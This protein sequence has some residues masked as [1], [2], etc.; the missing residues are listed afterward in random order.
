MAWGL[1][2][3]TDRIRLCRADLRRGRIHLRRA[4]ESPL[5]LGLVRASVKDANVTDAAAL[6]KVLRDL[7]RHAGCRGWVRVALPDPVFILRTVATEELPADRDEA[8][9]FLCWQVRDLLPFSAEHARLDFVKAGS[10][11]DGRSRFTCL[12]AND[13]IV[14]EY[15][16][17]L[18]AADLLPGALD[19][20]SVTLAQ[21]ASALL[22]FPSVGLL[23]A[24]GARVTLLVIQE[25]RPRLWRIMATDE[26]AGGNGLR[27][28]REVADSLVYFQETE[29]LGSLQHLFVH[30]MGRQTAEIAAGLTKWLELTVSVLDL[31]TGLTS[32]AKLRGLADELTRWGAAL[33]AAIRPW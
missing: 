33:G 6:T 16:Q 5:P 20:R 19:A 18:R 23:T 29:D 32:G 9:R 15:E 21:A 11:P 3:A 22:A 17:L 26:A 27:L 30:G 1:E 8:R 28:I 14:T 25:G 10:G 4:A 12:I 2:I 7:A 24:D 31:S 13:R